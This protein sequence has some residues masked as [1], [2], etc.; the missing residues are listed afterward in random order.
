[1]HDIHYPGSELELYRSLAPNESNFTGTLFVDGSQPVCQ[2]V[3]SN[4]FLIHPELTVRPHLHY[5]DLIRGSWPVYG[6][7]LGHHR[8]QAFLLRWHAH[9]NYEQNQQNID[10]RNDIKFSVRSAVCTARL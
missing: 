1:V 4:P 9:K 6:C 8:F 10:Q 7:R 3:P 5:H 2:V